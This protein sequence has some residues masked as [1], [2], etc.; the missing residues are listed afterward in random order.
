MKT[1]L[2]QVTTLVIAHRLTTIKNADRIIVMDKGRIIE[3]G[4][5]EELMRDYPEGLYANMVSI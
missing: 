1:E 4:S 5:H 2:G 3:D